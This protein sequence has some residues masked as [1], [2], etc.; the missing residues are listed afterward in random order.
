MHIPDG[1]MDVKTITSTWL[2]SIGFLSYGIKRLTSTLKDK[3]IPLMGVMSAFVFAAQMI[4][5]PI[6]GGTSGHFLGGILLAIILGPWAGLLSISIVLLIQCLIFQDG[7]LLALGANIFNMGIIG[8]LCSYYFFILI[9][10]L[11]KN[12]IL[13]SA[14]IA[15]WFSVVLA[16]IFASL[17][18]SISGFSPLS[19][20]LP[21]MVG[22]H[23]IIGIGEGLITYAVL[24]IVYTAKP[25]L[26]KNN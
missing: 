16:S 13:L 25:E 9:R 5:Y 8:T 18:I 15:A 21:A 3:L 22:V 20:T 14:S 17:E 24:V 26:I 4:N 6:A 1:L 2:F 19:I 7:G 23:S 12:N 11:L 10:K